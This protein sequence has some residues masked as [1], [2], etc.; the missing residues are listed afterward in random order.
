MSQTTKYKLDDFL[1]AEDCALIGIVSSAPAYNLCWHL[2]KQL[3]IELFRCPDINFEIVQKAKKYNGPDLF[4]QEEE[5]VSEHKTFSLHHGFKYNDESL[6]SD[7]Y[8][9]SNKGTL[10]NLEPSLKKVNY[11]FEIV[12][13]Q[14]QQ[15]E[16]LV[17]L[18]NSIEPVSMAYLIGQESII[19][20]LKLII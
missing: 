19:N 4:Q 2:N 3:N 15:A 7:Y 5:I 17:F 14:S 18:L 13:T 11:F 8:L 20:K 6:Y 16:Q 9:I 12:G 1:P 10:V